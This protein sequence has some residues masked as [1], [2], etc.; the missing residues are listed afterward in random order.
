[1][2][3][4]LII[5]LFTFFVWI[6]VTN[7]TSWRTNADWCHNSSTAW[8]H[9]H[10]SWY[11]P[12]YDYSD[13]SSDSTTTTTVIREMSDEDIVKQIK[14]GIKC[15]KIT[16]NTSDRT[17]CYNLESEGDIYSNNEILEELKKSKSCNRF[18]SL[19]HN[20]SECK[21]LIWSSNIYTLDEI[22]KATF[23]FKNCYKIKSFKEDYKICVSEGKLKA[24]SYQ[25][26]KKLKEKKS[27]LQSKI[28]TINERLIII[29]KKNPK[30]IERL[31]WKFTSFK[32]KLKEGTDTY[33]LV[34]WIETKLLELLE[35]NY[36]S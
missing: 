22:K 18:Y 33:I 31:A 2:K 36:T 15:S 24:Q 20:Y 11:T 5:T 6:T 26:N 16:T 27:K 30:S 28:D 23:S 19:K 9:C 34:E 13:Y 14:E 8:Y 7:A 1:M 21:G 29:N 10:N 12:T 32:S 17:A 35:V 4:L 3:K 25:E